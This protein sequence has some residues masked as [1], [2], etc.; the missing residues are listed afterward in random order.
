M[1]CKRKDIGKEL[2]GLIIYKKDQQ[3]IEKNRYK[4][5]EKSSSVRKK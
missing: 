5:A 3:I 1:M 2:F 4:E